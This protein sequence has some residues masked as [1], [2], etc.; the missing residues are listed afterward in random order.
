MLASDDMRG[1]EPATLDEWR[2]SA[3]I[4]ELAREV[5]GDERPQGGSGIGVGSVRVGVGC[6]TRHHDGKPLST[7]ASRPSHPR[8]G[9]RVVLQH[10]AGR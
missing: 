7:G 1:R 10:V 8:L 2:A 9:S 3:W 6:L 4:A 5:A